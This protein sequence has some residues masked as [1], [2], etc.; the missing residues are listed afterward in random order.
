MIRLGWDRRCL[1]S[2]GFCRFRVFLVGKV[3]FLWHIWKARIHYSQPLNF[4]DFSDGPSKLSHPSESKVF[5]QNSV[6]GISP[7][8][9]AFLSVVAHL[10][11]D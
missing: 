8:I 4:S 3:S 9:P 5:T 10:S 11:T 6:V 1:F 2:R 7:K